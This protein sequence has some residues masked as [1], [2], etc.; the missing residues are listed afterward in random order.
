[1]NQFIYDMPERDYFAHDAMSN[2]K[3]KHVEKSPAHYMAYI[4][5]DDEEPS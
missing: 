5:K 1:M 3:L 4:Q 2:S